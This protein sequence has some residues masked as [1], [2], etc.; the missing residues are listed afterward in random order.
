MCENRI[1]LLTSSCVILII[2][3]IVLLEGIQDI[4]CI[5]D[6]PAELAIRVILDIIQANKLFDSFFACEFDYLLFSVEQNLTIIKEINLKDVVTESKHYGVF[7]LQ[8][9]PDIY[10]IFSFFCPL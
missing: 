8:P 6:P 4:F 7:G 1:G 10:H 3:P 9:L 5:L 2:L